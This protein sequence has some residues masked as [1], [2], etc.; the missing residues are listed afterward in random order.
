MPSDEAAERAPRGA[1]S[2]PAGERPIL[3]TPDDFPSRPQRKGGFLGYLVIALV[4]AVMAAGWGYVLLLTGGNTQVSAQVISYDASAADSAEITFTVHKPADR[5]AMCRLRALDEGHLEVGSRVIDVPRG[6]AE[7]AFTE[8][9]RTSAR[10]ATV[11][12]D[13]C[14]LV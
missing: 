1:A 2:E 3:G 14:D 4:I 7:L 8:R 10:A 5:A 11:F 6:K 12:V 13:Y 9:L